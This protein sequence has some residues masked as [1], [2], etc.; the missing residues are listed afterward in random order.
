METNSIQAIA[1]KKIIIG[2]FCILLCTGLKLNAQT[3]SGIGGGMGNWVYSS[4]IYNG[5]L[6][7]GGV[8]TSAGGVS[9][10]HIARWNGT[11]WSPLGLGVNGKVNALIVKNGLL[12]VGGEFTEAGGQ[13][14][15]YIAIWDGTQW[16]NDLGD[17]GSIVTSFA[18][19]NNRLIV[20]GYFT[21][22]DGV[23]LNY[24]AQ[25]TSAGWAALGSGVVGTEGQVMAMT[26]Y[27]NELIVGGFFTAAG[28]L[29]ANHVAKWNGTTWSAIG[30]GVSGIVYSF[31]TYNGSLITGGLFYTAGGVTVNHI[32]SW[33]GSNWSAL[34]T[35][36]FGSFY[37]YVFA[38]GVFDGKLMAGGYFTHSGGIPTNGIAQWDG[39]TWSA[40]GSGLFMPGNVCG[41]H[42]FCNYGT[43]FV[44]GG[45][46]NSAGN[47]SNT[48]HIA[49]IS[50][51]VLV[52]LNLKLFI[53]G[54]YSGN[55]LM[56]NSGD[57]GCLFINGISG[58][59]TD[60]D[61]VYVSLMSDIAP[62]DEVEQQG[63]I[64]Q[65]NGNVSVTF[66]SAIQTGQA[67]Y[68]RIYHRNALETW[69]SSAVLMNT[70]SAYDFTTGS[71]KAYG[72]NMIQ[73]F[74]HLYWAFYSGDISDPLYG[75]GTQDGVIDHTDFIDLENGVSFTNLGYVPEDL[76][77]DGIVESAD[78][79]LM[80]NNSVATLNL[81]RP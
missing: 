60:A 65:T 62:Y 55:G 63:G 68:I 52:T 26:V 9:A 71:T 14:M 41:S 77:G 45:I 22:A 5:D 24:V 6:I 23:P 33:N 44:V 76:N 66:T 36:M 11:S 20:G 46:F 10:N 79:A 51:P 31:T 56:D 8:F 17:M 4:V 49:K 28:G 43:D 2:I 38:L 47:A 13:V 72:S 48:F 15:N 53:Q 80:E 29:P 74:D 69:S 18:I 27:N 1:G 67:Y 58:S 25:R 50:N 34:G 3:W 54:Y 7:V 39:S 73:T 40:L 32:A 37:Q 16:L 12:Y 78:Y 57:G 64:L 35:G 59:P 61:Y 70:T 19:F 30:S 81:I 75:M 42:T 21:D